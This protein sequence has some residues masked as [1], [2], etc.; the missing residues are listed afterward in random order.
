MSPLRKLLLAAPLVLLASCNLFGNGKPKVSEEELA[1][2]VTINPF[3][4]TLTPDPAFASTTVTLPTATPAG[5]WLQSGVTAAKI[6][7]N[8]EAAPEFKIAWKAKVSGSSTSKRI[9]AAPVVKDNRV[10]VIDSDQHVFAFDAGNGHKI[11]QRDLKSTNSKRDKHSVGGGLAIAGDKL[12]VASGYSFVEAMNLATG[13]QIW[14][15]S[16]D[17]PMSSSPAIMGN[18][19]F[20]TSTNNEFY[21]LDTDTGEVLWSDQAIAETARVL[22]SP[23]PAVTADLLA[24]PY[25]SGQLITYVPQ[26]GQRLWS[27]TLSTLGRYT[28]LSVINDIAGRPS[29]SD[30]MVFAA[31]QS[32][33]LA[34]YEAR[35]GSP[36][37]KVVF[38]SRQGPVIEG[39]FLFIVGVEGKVVCFNKVDGKII[40]VRELPLYNKPKDK[41]ER[42]V[43]VGPLVVSG[44]LMV[45]SS[46][47]QL[48]A[49]S[50]QDG[51]TVGELKVG[52]TV[53]I[54]P[55]A[56][57]GKIFLLDDKGTLIAVK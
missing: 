39:Q 28:P 2:R 31:S 24:V 22:S 50:P 56:A 34:A 13:A 7:G 26:N 8:L 38:G 20:L 4:D 1:A 49:L 40:W 44:K 27:D 10:Y 35:S 54:E 43:W 42:I 18:R 45:A 55:I 5:D 48:L 25:S 17:T 37:W 41:K 33:V 23:S 19:A 21:S 9:V 14:R 53:Y 11:W 3:Q 6:P 57:A 30:G 52:G 16:L 47:G 12:I 36:I 32:G 15:R 29:I 51:K 46:R